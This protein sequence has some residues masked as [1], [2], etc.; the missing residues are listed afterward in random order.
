MGVASVGFA[1][2]RHLDV[3]AV[4]GEENRKRGKEGGS[5]GWWPKYV[6]SR[7][8]GSLR[9]RVIKRPARSLVKKK[10]RLKWARYNVVFCFDSVD[11]YG[12]GEFKPP[13]EKKNKHQKPK[14]NNK[15]KR[16]KK[17]TQPTTTN[18]HNKQNQ[19]I[20]LTQLLMD[21]GH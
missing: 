2:T 9:E 4:M 5:A 1:R 11:I 13:K 15:K 12:R 16:K 21:L 18:T 14:K 3:K 17:H 6:P 20:Y 8:E 10:R 19:H 7:L